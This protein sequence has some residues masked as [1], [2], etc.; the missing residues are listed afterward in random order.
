MIKSKKKLVITS[1][2]YSLLSKFRVFI[3][4]NWQKNHIFSKKNK[5]I[6]FYYYSKLKRKFNFFVAILD[7]KLIGVQGFIP[8]KFFD[9]NIGHNDIFL[10][11]WRVIKTDLI[12]IGYLLHKKILNYTKSN[13]IGVIGINSELIN[14]HKW[15]GFVVKKMF[16]YV[17]VSPYK[18]NFK[19]LGY[20][21]KKIFFVNESLNFKITYINN[22]KLFKRI[23]K[24]IFKYQT[25]IK[26]KNYLLNRY[27]KNNFYKYQVFLI[28]FSKIEQSVIVTRKINIKNTSVIK[29]VDYIGSNSNIR[30]INP[31][32]KFL[33]KKNNS[34]FV[35]IYFYGIPEKNLKAAG[36][37]KVNK[38]NNIVVPNH[39][40]PFEKKNI[41]INCAYKC[42]NLKNDVRIFRGD[43][44][45]D[46]PS[47]I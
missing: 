29:I 9:K 36:F 19:I 31:F 27:F 45:G 28:E 23:K 16:H 47:E 22:T 2:N 35:D 34:E 8:L 43:G 33:T 11:F 5:I 21:R 13:F 30:K 26:S 18:E 1:L 44:D 46:R 38:K 14:F 10:A 40:E 24:S 42:I 39:Y 6:N 37:I 41:T 32:L 12:G 7:N 17:Y 4:K 25:P 15:R 20:K 3:D